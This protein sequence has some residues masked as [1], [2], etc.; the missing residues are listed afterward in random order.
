MTFEE[1]AVYFTKNEWIRLSPP[2]EALYRDVMLENYEAVALLAGPPAS[3]PALISQLKKGKAPMFSCKNWDDLDSDEEELECGD[4]E[5][6]DEGAEEEEEGAEERPPLGAIPVTDCLFCSHHS[7]SLMRNVAHITKAHSSFVPDVEY[8]CD[9]KGLIR[10]LGEKVGVGKICLWCNGKGRSF[11]PT[12]AVQPH[13]N[14]KSH[15]KLFTD[16]NAALEFADFYDFR[17]SYPDHKEGDD[18]EEALPSE[19]NVE[20]DDETMVLVLPSG[21]RVG[22][23]SVMRYCRQRFGLSRAVTVAKNKAAVGRVLQQYRALGWTGSTGA[24][25][26]RE[27]DM[28]YVQR[29][30]SKWMLKTGMKNNATKQMH[31]RAQVRF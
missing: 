3:K 28:Q 25:L 20:Y 2:Q 26:M 12:E 7:S 18:S 30:K 24:A 4:A 29:M 13:M 27:R 10:Y 14:D 8:L 19:K 1:V 16:G 21:A 23:R 17:S 6:G 22:Y 31:V 11:Y 9:L 15:C 5:T